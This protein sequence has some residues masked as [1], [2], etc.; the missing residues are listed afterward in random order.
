MTVIRLIYIITTVQVNFITDSDI[1]WLHLM[2][3]CPAG[4]SHKCVYGVKDGQYSY[5]WW[6]SQERAFVYVAGVLE[7]MFQY[8][9]A[10]HED[11]DNIREKVLK[12][13]T[14]KLKTLPEDTLDKDAEDFVVTQCRKVNIADLFS[15]RNWRRKLHIWSPNYTST[16]ALHEL[17]KWLRFGYAILTSV[18]RS[19][20]LTRPPCSKG[21]WARLWY[22]RIKSCN[23]DAVFGADIGSKGSRNSL[24]LG[25]NVRVEEASVVKLLQKKLSVSLQRLCYCD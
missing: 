13:L 25:K 7:G 11:D 5:Y 9:L 17:R 14:Q 16:L 19:Y 3:Y 22:A 6:N 1:W 10:E 20:F 21:M 2:I 24:Q 15:L 4:C 23:S 8:I 12:F 18:I